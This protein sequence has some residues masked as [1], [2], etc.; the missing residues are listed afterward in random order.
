MEARQEP[1]GKF[2]FKEL[3]NITSLQLEK[4]LGSLYAIFPNQIF[5][6][7]SGTVREFYKDNPTLRK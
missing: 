7:F 1:I 6:D 5:R 2:K 4:A 3:R